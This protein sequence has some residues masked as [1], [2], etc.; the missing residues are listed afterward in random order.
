MSAIVEKPQ[1]ESFIYDSGVLSFDTADGKAAGQVSVDSDLLLS[2]MF[3]GLVGT[4]SGNEDELRHAFFIE[5]VAETCNWRMSLT[6]KSKRVSE[7]VQKI[8]LKG[9]DQHL[10]ELEIL[11]ANGDRSILTISEQQ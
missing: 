2:A 5:F 1:P 6:P 9:R 7:K 3:S 11:Q 10:D 8:D 4:L